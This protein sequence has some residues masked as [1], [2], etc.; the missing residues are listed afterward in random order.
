MLPI[1]YLYRID[2]KLKKNE[3]LKLIVNVVDFIS[4]CLFFF[5]FTLS[6]NT[7]HSKA[8][9][10]NRQV[11]AMGNGGDGDDGNGDGEG[12][13]GYAHGCDYRGHGR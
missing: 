10:P 11:E 12:R 9:E 5:N 8:S 6:F 2:R 1:D 4:C 13:H 7:S 3:T